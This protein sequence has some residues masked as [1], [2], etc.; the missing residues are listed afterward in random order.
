M[1]AQ[2]QARIF[3]PFFTTKDVDRGTGLGLS[4][5]YGIVKQS[6]GF[7]WVVSAP[8]KGSRFEVYLP[9]ISENQDLAAPSKTRAHSIVTGA[10]TILVV[11]DDA[12]VRELACKFLDAAGYHTLVAQDG[13]EA[14]QIAK[15]Y[16]RPIGA[17][18]T[19]VVMPKMRGTEL[20]VRLNDLLPK[21]KVIF[22]SGY[23]DHNDESPELVANSEFLEKPFTRESI[24]SKVNDAF[25]SE[26][27][28]NPDDCVVS[29]NRPKAR[30]ERVSSRSL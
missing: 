20:A 25:R 27:S 30:V 28:A 4:T 17:L 2:M 3:E 23:L 21:M 7:I 15:N 5:V 19:D 14:L 13:V 8:G 11:E 29:K 24:L 18:L 26:R 16:G 6:G 10:Q 9:M 12:A 22:M 1:D